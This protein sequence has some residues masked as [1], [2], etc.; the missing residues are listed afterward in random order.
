MTALVAQQ[1]HPRVLMLAA[2]QVQALPGQHQG[3]AVCYLLQER[4]KAV[5]VLQPGDQTLTRAVQLE[6]LEQRQAGY[7]W[8]ENAL[9]LEPLELVMRHR[10]LTARAVVH[11]GCIQLLPA[12]HPL[13]PGT[14]LLQAAASKQE[15]ALLAFAAQVHPSTG[16]CQAPPRHCA[17][18]A[19]LLATRGTQDLHCRH[20]KPERLESGLQCQREEEQ[21]LLA[22]LLVW[23][24]ARTAIVHW[25]VYG[26]LADEL[27]AGHNQQQDTE[28]Q[29]AQV[30]LLS[31]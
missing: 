11:V 17:A 9:Q 12:D 15:V 16:C 25:Q 8:A 14:W 30:G 21:Q 23:T 5:A 13:Q 28:K 20:S 18:E 26:R 4:P 7:V 10:G 19:L 29:A 31:P 3:L 2:V 22:D 24:C 6:L 27:V 1:A